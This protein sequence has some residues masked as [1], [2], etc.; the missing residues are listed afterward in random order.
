[1]GANNDMQQ[2]IIVSGNPIIGFKYT[3]P[4]ADSCTA[5]EW[6]DENIANEYDYWLVTLSDPSK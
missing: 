4:F 5:L 1:M 3:G 6:A 2:Y